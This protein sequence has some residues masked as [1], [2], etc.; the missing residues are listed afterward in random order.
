MG[1]SSM[2]AA[3][4]VG[5]SP[6]Q[7]NASYQPPFI[8]D[9]LYST[10]II[11]QPIFSLFLNKF[12]HEGQTDMGSKLTFG[13]YNLQ[14]YATKGSEIAWHMKREKNS[15]ALKLSG[16]TLVEADPELS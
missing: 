16:A 8:V 15:W 2:R 1:Y 12:K 13:S 7:S 11:E 14:K 5:L 10:G 6:M 3:G 4:V 9:L